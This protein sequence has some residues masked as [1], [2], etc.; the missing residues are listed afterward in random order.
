VTREENGP[1]RDLPGAFVSPWLGKTVAADSLSRGGV[2]RL[3]PSD[4]PKPRKSAEKTVFVDSLAGDDTPADV[5]KASTER[6]DM[7]KKRRNI[8]T[9]PVPEIPKPERGPKPPSRIAI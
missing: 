6:R 8:D 5:S 2:N 9:S 3:T 7:S 4:P 1:Y